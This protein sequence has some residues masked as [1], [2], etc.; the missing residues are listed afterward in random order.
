MVSLR[1]IPKQEHNNKKRCRKKLHIYNDTL[2][3]I[4]KKVHKNNTT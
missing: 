2:I 4:V 3:L 1:K